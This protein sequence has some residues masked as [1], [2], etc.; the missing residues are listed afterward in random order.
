[1]EHKRVAD[2]SMYTIHVNSAPSRYASAIKTLIVGHAKF[3][4]AIN[5]FPTHEVVGGLIAGPHAHAPQDPGLMNPAQ[6]LS[7]SLGLL[8]WR[9][10]DVSTSV[11]VGRDEASELMTLAN[12]NIAI[13]DV[14]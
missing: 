4:A 8:L 7:I 11:F 3:G 6:P 10:M 13:N 9:R 5:D 12:E 2:L 14:V 1:M